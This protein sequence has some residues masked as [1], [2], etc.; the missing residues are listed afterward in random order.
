MD[1]K[2]FYYLHRKI[3]EKCE[4]ILIKKGEKGLSRMNSQFFY[5]YQ[6]GK[7][8]FRNINS[9]VQTYLIEQKYLGLKKFRN[10]AL[11]GR[12]LY[13]A[14][15]DYNNK[16][17]QI[18][19]NPSYYLD[20]YLNFLE[21]NNFAELEK[22]AKDEVVIPDKIY[23]KDPPSF[24]KNKESLEQLKNNYYKYLIGLVFLAG[25]LV[26]HFWPDSQSHIHAK[27]K[28]FS[29]ANNSVLLSETILCSG[30]LDKIPEGYHIWLFVER[31]TLTNDGEVSRYWPKEPELPKDSLWSSLLIEN[32]VP[33]KEYSD[34]FSIS[35]YMLNEEGHKKVQAWLK[36]SAV[37][38]DYIPF[39]SVPYFR[40]PLDRV[41]NL[42]IKE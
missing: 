9:V 42:I 11:G 22:L 8:R 34:F 16:N 31:D 40:K 26:F 20:A 29:P 25:L 14:A 32:Y 10:Q 6:A 18:E 38:G 2:S 27:G 28:I 35:L 37:T 5:G 7:D 33:Q 15:K 17:K 21:I 36:H 1:R 19:I 23:F 3:V 41:D 13:E 4:N 30:S 39:R 24:S 12:N